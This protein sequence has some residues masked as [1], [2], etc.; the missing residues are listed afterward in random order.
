MAIVA[1][2]NLC[3]SQFRGLE[4][5]NA[6]VHKAA[7]VDLA[8]VPRANGVVAAKHA[9]P[10]PPVPNGKAKPKRKAK[11]KANRA[12]AKGKVATVRQKAKGRGVRKGKADQPWLEAGVSRATWFRAEREKRERDKSKGARR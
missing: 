9:D 2:C 1:R 3:G 4:C 8:P 10:R 11:A 7:K 6:A 12:G 5:P